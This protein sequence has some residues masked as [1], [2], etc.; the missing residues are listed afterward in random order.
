MQVADY[1]LKNEDVIDVVFVKLSTFSVYRLEIYL[2]I[3]N[4]KSY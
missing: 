1:D 3:N 2:S 4:Q